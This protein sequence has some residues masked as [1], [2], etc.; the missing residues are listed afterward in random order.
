LYLISGKSKQQQKIQQ[1]KIIFFQLDT[2]QGIQKKRS[3]NLLP[4]GGDDTNLLFCVLIDF[5]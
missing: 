2:T 4:S 5:H 1:G 3:Q